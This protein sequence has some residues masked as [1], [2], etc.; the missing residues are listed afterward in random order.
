MT[1]GENKISFSFGSAAKKAP[2]APSVASTSG[3]S[4]NAPKSNLEMLMAKAKAP[5]PSMSATS[6]P[7]PKAPIKFDDDDEDTPIQP[8]ASGSKAPA[9]TKSKPRDLLEAGGSAHINRNTA[10]SRS[11]KRLQSEALALDATA[12]QYDEVYDKLKAAER[13][14]ED[15][16]KQETTERKSKYMESFLESA[17]RRK[18][19]ALHA[20]EKMMAIEREKEGG[21]F[22]DKEKF[23]TAAYKA[24][25]E[26]VRRAEEEERI[27]EGKFIVLP[28]PDLVLTCLEQLRKSSKGAG[29]T[30][31]Y[32]SM[33]EDSEA[34]HAA[35]V[36]STTVGMTDSGP[37]LAIKP[38]SAQ[39]DEYVDDEAEY[40]PM[41]AREAASGSKSGTSPRLDEEK[42]DI[43]SGVEINDDGEVVD[44]R[45]L[46]KPGLNITKKPKPTASLPDS[47]KT[48]SK[49]TVPLVGPYQSRAVGTAASHGERMA[50]ERKRLE[51]QIKLEAEKKIRDEQE[52]VRL[53]EEE[54]RKRKEGDDGEAEKRRL[55]AK[56]RFL[57]R[58]RA[59]EQGGDGSNKKA[60]DGE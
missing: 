44:K 42:K 50:R 3:P 28:S 29:L 16:K 26:E 18:M 57:A 15:A 14:V 30:S 32:K 56:E 4:Q 23:V 2:S 9:K 8:I 25:M 13:K 12:F 27:K 54:A 55:E 19:D 53:E 38:P 46:L 40:D 5:Q 6:K 21:E 22:D 37:S 20:E 47:L 35:A 45:T 17:R 1:T 34:K 59:R 60:K 36:A 43:P 33:L 39:R 49:N 41:L 11:E 58:K 10:I 48:G 31:F 52:R 7:K 24:Q 51:E